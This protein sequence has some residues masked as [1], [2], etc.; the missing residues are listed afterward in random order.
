[1]I[2]IFNN[3]ALITDGEGFFPDDRARAIDAC[4]ILYSPFLF[5][6]YYL[7]RVFVLEKDSIRQSYAVGMYGLYEY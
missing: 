4:V 3:L 7:E 5:I 2:N 1:M 6:T